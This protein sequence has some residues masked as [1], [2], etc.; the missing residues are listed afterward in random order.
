MQGHAQS[1]IM[2]GLVPATFLGYQHLP[3]G[4]LQPVY[5]APQPETYQTIHTAFENHGQPQLKS[6]NDSLVGSQH[7]CCKC[8]KARSKHYHMENPVKPGRKAPASCC[9]SCRAKIT[10]SEPRVKYLQHFCA[11][12]GKVRSRAYHNEHPLPEGQTPRP[13]Y[14]L[15]CETHRAEGARDEAEWEDLEADV[16]S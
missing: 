16:S 10:N 4:S 8:G 15:K 3:D 2:P 5:S 7:F 11:E 13:A 12:C 6:S 14:C 1:A 9:T